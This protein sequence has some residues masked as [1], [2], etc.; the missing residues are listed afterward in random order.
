VRRSCFVL[1]VFLLLALSSRVQCQS[2]PAP[3]G[4]NAVE[5]LRKGTRLVVGRTLTPGE[6]E[7]RQPC[8]VVR[9]DTASLVCTPLG[10]RGSRLVYPAR[11]V[12]SVYV[13]KAHISPNILKMIVYG[14]AG[15]LAGGIITDEN[16]DYPLAT[17]GAIG[18][19]LSGLFSNPPEQRQVLIYKRASD[20]PG[21]PTVSP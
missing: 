16:W 3:T 21:T 12:A 2:T 5:R 6:Y 19:G 14:G 13:C 7:E 11:Q 4:W 17:I 8:K 10:G 15:W 1:C 20:E 9:V 18:G